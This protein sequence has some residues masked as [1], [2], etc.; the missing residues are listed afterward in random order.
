M[1]A[2]CSKV[3]SS[4]MNDCSDPHSET[5]ASSANSVCLISLPP[6]TKPTI[7][8]LLFI[9]RDKISIH[10]IKTYTDKGHPCRAPFLLGRSLIGDR[11]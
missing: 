7:F 2:N 4:S 8:A 11:Y 1:T 5:L 6:K 3:L 10:T 9:V